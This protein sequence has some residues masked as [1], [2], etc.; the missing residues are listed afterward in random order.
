[1]IVCKY[2]LLG[3]VMAFLLS[4]CNSWLDVEPYDKMTGEQVYASEQGIQRKLNGLYLQMAS[5]NLYAKELSCGVLDVLAQRYYISDS[6][7]SYYKLSRYQYT[8]KDVK[9]FF[10]S[11][12]SSSWNLVSACNELLEN[13]PKHQD[14]LTKQ[15]NSL[16]LGEAL[17]VRTYVQFDLFRLFAPVYSADT[18][19]KPAIPLYDKPTDVPAP[20]LTCG[21]VATR[22]LSDIDSASYLLQQ[23]PILTEGIVLDDEDFWAY[24]NVRMNYYA[25]WGLKA[26][27][28]WYLGEE[29]R[30]EAYRIATSLLEGK[31]P[32]SGN[33]IAFATTFEAVTKEQS[34]KD[35][36]Y[37]PE[38]LF[39]LHNLNRDQLY[40]NMFS[41]DLDTKVIFQGLTSYLG[42][43]YNDNRD[44]RNRFWEQ[45]SSDEKV[46]VFVRFYPQTI[47][48]TDKNPYT[49]QI[50]SLMRMSELYLIAAA[51][52][53][54]E[55][56]K[57]EWLEKGRLNRGYQNHNLDGLDVNDVLD[58]EWQR[59]FYGEGQ[60]FFYLKRNQVE[61][62]YGQDGNTKFNMMDYYQI[63]LP[64]SEVNNRYE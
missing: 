61:V 30:T 33:A 41:Q 19:N 21:E 48:R 60:Y 58:K 23:D 35:R 2:K 18:E 13:L 59:E 42:A 53:R 8:D 20:I 43:L 34:V 57:K 50:Q 4:G 25:A 12:W 7:H 38:M 47:N 44:Y 52:T 62:L 40:K 64:E 17:A 24:R 51:T 27:M 11:I 46:K 54:D 14:V 55:S 22:L 15:Q 1:M 63:P 26:R 16:V 29:Y 56:L 28:C 9:P 39:C 49:Y 6:E 32:K 5:E 37:F 31:D 3:V 10:E 36:V 45:S